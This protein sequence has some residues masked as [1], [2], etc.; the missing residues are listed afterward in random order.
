MMNDDVA[1]FMQ[2]AGSQ[3]DWE[4]ATISAWADREAFSKEETS[5]QRGV[6]TEATQGRRG[7][8]N[9]EWGVMEVSRVGGAR[10]KLQVPLRARVFS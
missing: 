10:A 6:C 1:K 9:E 8:L 4:E 5:E 3:S 2:D 7:S